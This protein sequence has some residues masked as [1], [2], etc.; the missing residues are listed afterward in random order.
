MRQDSLQEHLTVLAYTP[1]DRNVLL[2]VPV[3]DLTDFGIKS[4]F[5]LPTSTNERHRDALRF[6][7]LEAGRSFCLLDFPVEA[8]RRLLKI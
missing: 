7:R 5:V 8:R 4:G 6:A 2:D 1:M 3:R